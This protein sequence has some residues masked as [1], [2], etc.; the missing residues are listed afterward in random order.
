MDLGRISPVAGIASSAVF[1]ILWI[2]AAVA[3]QSWELGRFSLSHLGICG[4]DFSEICFNLGCALS[5]ILGIVF[6]MGVTE[7]KGAFRVCGIAVLCC[8]T[9]ITCVGI[10][11]LHYGD[12]H[13]S[14]AALYG[15]A[16]TICMVSSAYGDW[17]SGERKLA[18]FTS[19]ML[20]ACAAVMFTQ[21]FEV[22][23]PFAVCCVLTWTV[24]QSV[25]YLRSPFSA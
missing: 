17:R 11:N 16:A 14:V 15:L 8:G 3:D 2:A 23:E 4:N 22:F 1:L 7:Q 10:I 5:G 25:K 13:R 18:L 20:L 9:L 19:A 6:G 21:R 12:A 24:S